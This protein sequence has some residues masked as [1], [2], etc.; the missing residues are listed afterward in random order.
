MATLTS[1]NISA[2]HTSIEI[3]RPYKCS[4]C[5][6]AFHRLE[7]QTRHILTH[8][9]EKP[10]GCTS[11][12]CHK[13]FSRSDELTRHWRVHTNSNQRRTYKLS[14]AA[15]STTRS[16]AGAALVNGME[17]SKSAPTSKRGS[18][19]LSQLHSHTNHS[20][21]AANSTY[22]SGTSTPGSDILSTPLDMHILA[23]AASQQL[24]RENDLS[25]ANRRAPLHA[26][27]SSTLCS[28]YSGPTP[29]TFHTSLNSTTRHRGADLFVQPYAKR[30]R[31]NS[32]VLTPPS[33]PSSENLTEFT[34]FVTPT[35]SP[36]LHPCEL[37]GLHGLQ[38]PSIRS[39]PLGHM[40]PPLTPLE[41]ESSSTTSSAS[42][43]RSGSST[44]VLRML[45]ISDTISQH[46]AYF[47]STVMPSAFSSH[48]R[49]L[50]PLATRFT[51]VDLVN[52][53]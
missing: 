16:E 41:V 17:F 33:S 8:T 25:F 53:H 13:R 20:R 12:G 2:P 11:P 51:F 43:S 19:N 14:I 49:I 21:T 45:T 52:S 47:S 1:T 18:S 42:V 40:P 48:S 4:M 36:R 39:L 6:K 46:T 3:T 26:T 50:P 32:P 23:I 5:D 34:L 31:P 24:E 37:E 28:I 15:V 9:G 27:K 22:T 30:L 35:H 7:H 44:N 10:H 29:L 38:L